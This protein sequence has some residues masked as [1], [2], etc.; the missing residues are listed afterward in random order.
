MRGTQA[1]LKRMAKSPSLSESVV[2]DS[3]AVSLHLMAGRVVSLEE[4][5][6][7]TLVVMSQVM[8]HDA[9]AVLL[10]AYKDAGSADNLAFPVQIGLREHQRDRYLIAVVRVPVTRS[11][12]AILERTIENLSAWVGKILND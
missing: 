6:S 4:Q 5:E 3:N 12:D 1:L 8:E 10:R 2:G 11:D 7:A 9:A